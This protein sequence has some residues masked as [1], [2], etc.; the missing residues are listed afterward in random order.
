MTLL[1]GR[2]CVF[3]IVLQVKGYVLPSYFNCYGITGKCKKLMKERIGS[4][5]MYLLWVEKKKLKRLKLG[6][7]HALESSIITWAIW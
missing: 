2:L 4:G 1:L 5:F 3:L 6:A 7:L